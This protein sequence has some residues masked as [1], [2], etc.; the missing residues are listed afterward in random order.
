M[1]FC[2]TSQFPLISLVE[3]LLVSGKML[4]T[5]ICAIVILFFFSWMFMDFAPLIY[6]ICFNPVLKKKEEEEKKTGVRPVKTVGMFFLDLL[7]SWENWQF[8][9]PYSGT[10]SFVGLAT[11]KPLFLLPLIVY[12]HF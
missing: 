3:L 1:D 11:I 2:P 5:Y 12:Q 7:K 10:W 4:I 6:L 8:A 9:T